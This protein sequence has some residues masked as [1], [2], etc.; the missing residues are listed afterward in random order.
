MAPRVLTSALDG[1]TTRRKGA[2]LYRFIVG[3]SGPSSDVSVVAKWQ[4][5]HRWE[6]NPRLP[7][8]RR[9]EFAIKTNVMVVNI[10]E[11]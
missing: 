8:R 1:A 2:H 7:V 6:S 3:S 9:T 5:L 10:I 11:S 4:I